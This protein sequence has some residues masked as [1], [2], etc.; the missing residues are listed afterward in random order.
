MCRKVLPPSAQCSIRIRLRGRSH[1]GAA[2][3]LL[4]LEELGSVDQFL[5]NSV[6]GTST[7]QKVPI[8]KA[9]GACFYTSRMQIELLPKANFSSQHAPSG[10][11]PSP[12][13]QKPNRNL[14]K[15]ETENGKERKATIGQIRYRR[16][17]GLPALLP[18][19]VKPRNWRKEP[20]P[21]F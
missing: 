10:G 21:Q 14:S 9:L 11:G 8:G 4:T 16:E 12:E 6:F 3:R 13:V 17:R 1:W 20:R 7:R 18:H 15:S 5:W 2:S 19:R